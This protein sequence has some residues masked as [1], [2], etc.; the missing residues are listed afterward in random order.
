MLAPHS[1]QIVRRAVTATV[2]GLLLAGCAS[3][4]VPQERNG[5]RPDFERRGT[6]VSRAR[7]DLIRVTARQIGTPY[8]YG[9]TGGKG[10]D[11]SGLVYYA[12]RQIGVEVPR[13]AAEQWR[14]AYALQR[15]HL[16]PGDLLFFNLDGRKTSHVGIYEGGGMFIHAPSSG[17]KVSRASLDN[18]FWRERMVGVRTFL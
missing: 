6:P 7:S 8:R 16:V 4:Y 10:F 2:V 15:R 12:H 18:P 3:S 9:G 5:A 11:C 14:S 1:L 13:T 17:K